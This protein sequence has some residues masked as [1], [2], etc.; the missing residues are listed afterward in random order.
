MQKISIAVKYVTT[1]GDIATTLNEMMGKRRINR[2][3]KLFV[4][5]KM[6]IMTVFNIIW[7]FNH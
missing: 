6:L 4:T 1:K 3:F 2:R 5:Y 7:F